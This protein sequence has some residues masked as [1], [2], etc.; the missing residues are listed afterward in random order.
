MTMK[1]LYFIDGYNI[2]FAWDELKQLARESLEHSRERLQSLLASYGKAKGIEIVVVFDAMH[3]DDDG[4]YSISAPTAP[5]YLPIRMR[6]PTAESKSWFTLAGIVSG[7]FTSLPPMDRNNFRFSAAALAA[8]R[9][10]N[11]RTTSGAFAKRQNGITSGTAAL[12]TEVTVMKSFT[13]FGT[14]MF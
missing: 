4:K 1:D 11:W 2:I 8:Y 9:P 6:L 13:A 5:S 7:R 12:L 14:E 3:T 10:G